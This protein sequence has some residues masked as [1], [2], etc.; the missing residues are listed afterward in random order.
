MKAFLGFIVLIGLAVGGW[1]VYQNYYVH[2]HGGSGGGGQQ[3]HLETQIQ[4]SCQASTGQ[5]T[6]CQL[7]ITNLNTSNITFNWTAVSEPAGATFSPSSGSIPI[8]G[9]SDEINVTLTDCPAT[10]LF[11]DAEHNIQTSTQITTCS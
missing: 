3:S 2:G 4:S 9:Q 10:L 5:P 8:G 7:R 6:Q 11:Q 1:Y